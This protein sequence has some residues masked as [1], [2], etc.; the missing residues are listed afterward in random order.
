MLQS[1]LRLPGATFGLKADEAAL[2]SAIGRAVGVDL[3]VEPARVLPDVRHQLRHSGVAARRICAARVH[4]P[5]GGLVHCAQA[6][7]DGHVPGEVVEGHHIGAALAEAGDGADAERHGLE[8]GQLQ[9]LHV[10]A[11]VEDVVGVPAGGGRE[12]GQLR[13][14]DLACRIKRMRHALPIL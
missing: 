6:G 9:D 3:D 13:L 14:S 7:G 11:H 12:N 10:Q 8:E 4:H 5:V 1:S 2:H